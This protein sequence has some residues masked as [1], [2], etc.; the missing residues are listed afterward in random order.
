MEFDLKMWVSILAMGLCTLFLFF[1]DEFWLKPQRI[2]RKLEKQGIH[3]PRPSFFFGNI[4]EIKK[5]N[6]KAVRATPEPGGPLYHDYHKYIF[7]HLEQ[8]KK[9]YGPVFTFSIGVVPILHIADSEL[10]KELIQMKTIDL[11]KTPYLRKNRGAMLGNGIM[12]SSGESW[13]QQRKI[14]APEFFM[15]KIKGMTDMMLGS[16]GTLMDTWEKKVDAT[17]T[18]ATEINV[19]PDLRTYTADVISK[20]CFGSSFSEGKD[21]FS[22]LKTLQ[23]A[24]S[25]QTGDI[26]IPGLRYIPNES[27]REAWRLDREIRLSIMKVFKEREKRPVKGGKDL[28][29]VILNSVRD[30]AISKRSARSFIVDNSKTVYF[31]GH[32][33][34]ATTVSWVLLLLAK[35]PDW[36]HRVRAEIKEVCQGQDP[37][38][39]MISKLKLLTMVIQETMRL[40]PVALLT[41]REARRDMKIG[42]LDIPKGLN[43]WIP[44]MDLHL[45]PKLWGPDA[46]EFNPERFANGVS[47]AC[48]LPL[49]YIPFGVGP[50][51]CLGQHFAMVQ[52]KIVLAVILSKFAFVPSPTYRHKVAYRLVLGPEDTV[53]IIVKKV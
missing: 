38:A 51:I 4:P 53:N 32:E 10:A 12:A 39:D 25:K 16:L 48:K 42:D 45:N 35:H 47:G 27:N 2:R 26:G 3:G 34:S 5:I 19:D 31:A 20:A 44:T 17:G 29:Q 6:A 18:G 41:Q 49:A 40:Y 21:I 50:R 13:V 30:G 43:I 14:I 37:D 15:D 1:Y 22:Q 8:W 9:I 11:G 52:L 23:I 33:T 7:P 36:Q 24:L 46:L 28:L